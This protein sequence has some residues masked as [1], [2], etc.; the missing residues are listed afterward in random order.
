D[1]G[2]AIDAVGTHREGGI[3]EEA[4]L[5]ADLERLPWLPVLGLAL[6]HRRLERTHGISAALGGD[7]LAEEIVGTLRRRRR[8]LAGPEQHCRGYRNSVF[9]MTPS[10]VIGIQRQMIAQPFGG[11]KETWTPSP[12]RP[13]LIHHWWDGDVI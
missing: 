12:R 8:D 10:I 5:A 13:R 11:E 3:A 2:H 7:C 6:D 4:R 1:A 9:H